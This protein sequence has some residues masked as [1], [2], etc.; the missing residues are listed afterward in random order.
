[1][2]RRRGIGVSVCMGKS[3]YAHPCKSRID[4]ERQIKWLLH[5]SGE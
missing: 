3:A 2:E 1:M 4:E 5:G